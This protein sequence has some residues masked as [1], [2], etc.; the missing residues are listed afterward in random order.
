[1]Q[2]TVLG[3]SPKGDLSV[4]LQSIR[5]LEKLFPQHVFE[6]FHIGQ[7]IKA[8]EE[9]EEKRKELAE[10]VL[11]SDLVLF[12]Q[13]VYAFTIPS[14]VKRFI[15][16]LFKDDLGGAFKGKYAGIFTTSINFFDHLAHDYLR[17]VLE[18]LG[19]QVAGAYSAD[20]YDLLNKEEQKRLSAFAEDLFRT[21][22]LKRPVSR[23]F[24]PLVQNAFSYEPGSASPPLETGTRKVLIVQDKNYEDANLGRMISRLSKRFSRSEI[25]QLDTIFMAGPC[26]GCVQCGFDHRCVYTGKDD[27][28]ATYEEK[29][30]RA[31]ILVFAMKV[32]DRLFSSMWKV[33][34]D[35]GF[36]N[37]HTPSLRNKQLA[38]LVSG[39]F[40]QIG[41][42]R[43]MLM[44]F[45]EWQGANLLDFITD[46]CSDSAMIDAL[47]DTLAERAMEASEKAY[48]GPSSFLGK[49]GMKIFRDD[50]FGRHRFVFQAD[51]AWFEANGIYDFPQ[52]DKKSMDTNTFMF[53][54][55][56]DPDTKEAI[57]KMLKREMVKP[58]QKIVEKTGGS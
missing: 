11:S 49:A 40:S 54:I 51:H 56:K 6:T 20:S 16:L 24:F 53:E 34:F 4:S 8:L 17:S 45:T 10:A 41:F 9:N 12:C 1:M 19:M 2:I 47:L 39:P 28:I 7:G 43:E 30:K 35:R 31:D 3:G 15:E 48:V 18:D 13:P 46:E 21:I 33:F 42:F 58:H 50:V 32:E 52:D 44:A 37:T 36:Y 5:F 23:T 27:F 55:M 57:R 14:Q 22:A 26:I 38:Y 29:I 25:L